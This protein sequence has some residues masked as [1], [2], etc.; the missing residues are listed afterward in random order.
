MNRVLLLLTFL[1]LGFLTFAST[2]DPNMAAVWLASTDQS[3]D[4]LRSGVMA[5]LVVLMFTN[6]PRNVVLRI[7]VGIA[8]VGL[9][10]WSVYMVY[11]NVMQLLDGIILLAAGITSLVAVLE[12]ESEDGLEQTVSPKLTYSARS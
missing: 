5:M 1:S 12:Y 8:A 10:G 7:V 11:Q 3:Y 6:P 4:L 9:A 2:R